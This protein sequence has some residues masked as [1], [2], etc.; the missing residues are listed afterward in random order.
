M[1]ESTK[2]VTHST[3]LRC[4]TS[5]D[6][7]VAVTAERLYGEWTTTSDDVNYEDNGLNA[8]Q[9]AE[10]E[11][12][13]ADHYDEWIDDIMESFDDDEDSEEDED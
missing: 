3:T 1:K 4:G 10:V 7:E 5:V 13:I 6:V 2:T 9:I 11:S 8:D 12:F